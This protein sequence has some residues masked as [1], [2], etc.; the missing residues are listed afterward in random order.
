MTDADMDKF[1]V[2]RDIHT[3][4]FKIMQ[5]CLFL[6]GERLKGKKCR[7]E[8]FNADD[9]LLSHEEADA[10]M[11]ELMDVQQEEIALARLLV[12]HKNMIERSLQCEN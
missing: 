9:R 7:Y 6:Y 11:Q 2:E 12:K 5:H 10:C 8:K 3:A 4:R 1:K